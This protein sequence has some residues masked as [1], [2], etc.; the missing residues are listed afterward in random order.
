MWFNGGHTSFF[1]D[2]FVFL[3]WFGDAWAVII[4]FVILL[5]INIKDAFLVGFSGLISG[6]FA[7][8][9]K[10]IVFSNVMRPAFY[11]D[12]MPGLEFVEGVKLHHAFSFPSGHATSAFA[13][14]FALA[15][16]LKNQWLKFASFIIA[17]LIAF[18]RVYLSQHFMADIVAGAFLGLIVTFG[19]AI[20]LQ[21]N[22]FTRF[23]RPLFVRNK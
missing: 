23:D 22:M 3:T 19:V 4:V 6:F 18:S 16:I 14:F 11:M 17:S 9:L 10:R 5:F 15:L 8:L 2:V 1:D 13:L 20:W 12:K 7:Q 21:S